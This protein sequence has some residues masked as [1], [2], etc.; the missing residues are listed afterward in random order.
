MGH[1]LYTLWFGKRNCTGIPVVTRRTPDD[2]S[3]FFHM[4]AAVDNQLDYFLS[5]SGFDQDRTYSRAF[6]PV[7]YRNRQTTTH[8]APRSVLFSC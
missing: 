5:L 4:T 8:G 7:I 3:G 2:F 6:A 1:E